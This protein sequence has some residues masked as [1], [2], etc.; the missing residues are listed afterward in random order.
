MSFLQ[1]LPEKILLPCYPSSAPPR[2][3][4]AV[5]PQRSRLPPGEQPNRAS[6]MLSCDKRQEE[7][8]ENQVIIESDS[9]S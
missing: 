9:F 4:A 5:E 6:L 1:K 7:S 2:G 3:P 8:N